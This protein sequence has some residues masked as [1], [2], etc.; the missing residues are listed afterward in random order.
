[1]A[2]VWAFLDTHLRNLPPFLKRGEEGI[3]I[4][5]RTPR[6]LYDRVVAYYVGHSLPVPLSSSEF[7]AELAQ[8]YTLRDGMVFLAEQVPAYEQ[9]RKTVRQ[10]RLL[11]IAVADEQSAI[12]WLRQL[13]ANKPQTSSDLTPQFM[14]QMSH[15]SKHEQQ[16][17][18]ATLL[19]ENFLCY[20]DLSQPIPPPILSWLKKSSEQRERIH[21]ALAD[22]TAHEDSRQG[23]TTRDPRLLQAARDR[24]YLPD[25]GRSIDL[26]QARQ[27]GLLR[28]FKRYAEGQTKLRQF[29]AEAVRAGFAEAWKSRDYAIIVRVGARLPNDVLHTDPK[30]LMYYDNA[31]MRLGQ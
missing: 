16:I 24:W 14:Q 6:S 22:G 23:L 17:E 7:Q 8:H 1:V 19:D 30:L 18:L 21:A 5:E 26:E 25:P 3:E 9:Q 11:E 10:M 31:S 13:L 12:Q 20:N 4:I 27:K 28:E 29:R 2:G 15:W